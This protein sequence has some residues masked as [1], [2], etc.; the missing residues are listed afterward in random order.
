MAWGAASVG[1]WWLAA[2]L[3]AS[4]LIGCGRAAAGP[5]TPAADARAASAA[6]TA[7]TLRVV[8]DD[9]H[10][11]YLFR[12][13]DGQME[14]Y[15]VDY[16]RLWQQRNGVRVE[17]IATDWAAAQRT[18]LDGEADVIDMISPT[19]TRDANYDFSPPYADLPVAIF[20]HVDISGIRS[21]AA[22][23]GFHVGVQEGDA[24]IERLGEV[25]IT[26]LRTYASYEDL[27]SAAQRSEIK[28]FCLDE[29]PANFYLYRAGASH[30]FKKAFEFY[31]GDRK[32]VV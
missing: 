21:A 10:P 1:S 29:A 30:E 28:V 4:L 20:T 13:P 23:K 31:V 8:T 18:L 32:S 7:R 17:L 2:W 27:I 25:G 26:T 5:P 11:P 6:A 22:L 12:N 3:L 15:L 19:P 14:G 9:N 16:W 24:C